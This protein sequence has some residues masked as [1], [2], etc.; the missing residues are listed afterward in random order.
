MRH[1]YTAEPKD[2]VVI[3]HAKAFERRRCGHHTLDKPLSTMECFASVIDPKSSHTNKNRYVVATQDPKI[4][5]YLRTIPGVPVIYIKRSV[6]IMEPM[7]GATERVKER[8]EKAKFKAGIIGSRTTG[9]GQKRKRDDEEVS[10][11]DDS[12]E[13]GSL[14][15]TEN[16]TNTKLVKPKRRNGPK[17]PNPLSMKKAKKAT[18]GEARQLVTKPEKS[19]SV[20]SGEPGKRRRMRKHKKEGDQVQA[21][22]PTAITTDG[23]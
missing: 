14:G 19:T 17:E 3:D 15:A 9:T 5:A 21:N 10:G 6:M 4:R 12:D 23:T 13:D 18:A 16:Q 22:E 11:A 8:E 20:I 1:L 7:G 2:E